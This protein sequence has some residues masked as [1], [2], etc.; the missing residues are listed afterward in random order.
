MIKNESEIWRALPDVLG[1]EVSTLGNVRTLDRVISSEKMTCFKK[2]RVLKQQKNNKGYPIV[3]I[4]VDE[5]WTK[6]TVHRLIAKAFIPNPEE[7]PMVNHKDG[8]RENNHIDNL[9][10]CSASYNS[11]YREEFGKSLSKPVFAINLSTLEVTHFQSQIEAGQALGAN[12]G[13]INSVIKGRIKQT[14]GYWFVN[15]DNNA[16][17]TIKQKLYEI[18]HRSTLKMH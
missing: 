2:G 6:K 7:L 3:S 10:W 18:K 11:R 12:T 14:Y 15:D 5:K 17:D 13:N 9:E 1:I 8:N 16:A 4:P